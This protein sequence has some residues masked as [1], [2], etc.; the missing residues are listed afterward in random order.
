MEPVVIR[1][2]LVSV[3]DKTGIVDFCRALSESGVE[4]VST[5]GTAKALAA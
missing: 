2:A 4:I 1:R 5:G 3:T